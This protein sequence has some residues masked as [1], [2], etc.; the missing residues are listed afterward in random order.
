[1]KRLLGTA[2]LLACPAWAGYSYYLT[3]NL[4][5]IDNSKWTTTGSPAASR[6]GLSA[7]TPSGGT[8]ISRLPVPDGTSEGEVS[9]TLTVVASGGTYT[10]FLQASTDARTGPSGG[11]SYLAFEMQNPRFDSA[12]KCLANYMLLQS[13]AGTTRLVAGFLNSC[14]NGMVMRLA[15]HGGTAMVWPDLAAPMEFPIAAL[16]AGQPGIGAIA[17]PPGNSIALVQLGAI[18]RTAPARVAQIASAASWNRVDLQW[19]AVAPDAASP[20][21]AGY[22]IYRDGVYLGRIS[23]SVFSDESVAPGQT[24]AY[25]VSVVDQHGNLSPAASVTV[26]TPPSPATG[27]NPPPADPAHPPGKGVAVSGKTQTAAGA[28]NGLEPRRLGVKPTGTYWGGAGEQ[29]DM[30]FGNL[31]YTLPLWN[32]KSRGGWGVNFALTYNSQI[33]RQDSGGTW[34]FGQDVGYGMGWKLL[35]GAITPIW[36]GSQLDHY[37][38][39]DS[40]GAE[41]RLDQNNSGVWTSQEGIY[42]SY[43][44]NANRL[45]F[46]DGSFWVMGCVSGGS[47]QDAGT[48]YPTT[49]QDTNGNSLS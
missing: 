7:A 44:S 6:T 39:T 45:Y 5:A 19:H 13:T 42:V 43:D 24:Y 34:L 14:R 22:W 37:L 48:S 26:T 25:S 20:G 8:L 33:W 3:D 1:M 21:I 10:E 11:G 35:A 28:T 4:T 36:S 15:V 32:P 46:P 2:F 12:G 17:T 23:N 27:P 29:V 31:N 18:A 41:Y 30:L 9:M 40:T 47:E 49:M 16:A 38:S